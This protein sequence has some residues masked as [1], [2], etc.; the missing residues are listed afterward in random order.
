MR[1]TMVRASVMATLTVAIACDN[2][3]GSDTEPD[4]GDYYD[5]DDK[6]EDNDE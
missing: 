4:G 5:N 3:V 1:L 2:G 6:G